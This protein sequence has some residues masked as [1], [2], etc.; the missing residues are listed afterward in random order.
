MAVLIGALLAILAIGVILYPF[1]KARSRPRTSRPSDPDPG[2]VW[3]GRQGIYEEI[4]TL[5]LEYE[6]G[7]IE[8][9]EYHQRLR[10]FRLQAAGTLRDQ[11]HLELEV[12]RSLEEEIL[13]SRSLRGSE[14]VPLPCPY[15]GRTLANG[16]ELCPHCGA[17][18]APDPR[19]QG[20]GE[21]DDG[22]LP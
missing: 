8:E 21:G 15:C 3:A 5:Q 13:A 20:E 22:R 9:P 1:L 4:K 17:K 11:E 19:G 7:R 6:L 10:A 12:E 2:S 16:A 18:A 14:H